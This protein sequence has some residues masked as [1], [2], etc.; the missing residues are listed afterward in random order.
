MYRR[1]IDVLSDFYEYWE[2]ECQGELTQD[3]KCS[4]E[5]F[6]EWLDNET[7]SEFKYDGEGE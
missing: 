1:F 4:I 5:E 2:K 6:A 3:D 7:D